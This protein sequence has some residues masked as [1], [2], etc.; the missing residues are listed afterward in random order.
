MAIHER[1]IIS[2]CKFTY[3][4]D[5]MTLKGRL[6]YFQHRNDRDTHVP[7][8]D[9]EGNAVRRWYDQGLGAGY[10]EIYDSCQQLSTSGLKRDVLGRTMV[11]S[12]QVEFMD[13]IPEARRE[14]VLCE[15]TENTIA[16]W[17]EA[18]DKPIPE[19]SYV[20]HHGESKAER[21]EGIKPPPPDFMHTHVV[22]AATTSEV[23]GRETYWVNKPQLEQLREVSQQEME[24]LWTRELGVERVEDLNQELEELTQ[25]LKALDQ[26]REERARP[27]P[28][29][30]PDEQAMDQFLNEIYSILEVDAPD[31]LKKR[32]TTYPEQIQAVDGSKVHNRQASIN[33]SNE[34]DAFYKTLG[35]PPAENIEREMSS[36]MLHD[37]FDM[38]L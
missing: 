31:D 13:A 34:V 10:Q 1:A 4:T 19:Y 6:K 26:E 16:A 37:D 2:N 15:L 17:F 27:A 11:V 28:R 25:S 5:E 20:V 18:M 32:L 33:I 22:L 3:S 30:E 9:E 24:Q 21:P 29:L 12:P 8:I 7:Q 14:A 36:E 35:I 38:D 23:A